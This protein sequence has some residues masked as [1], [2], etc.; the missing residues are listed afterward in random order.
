MW[1][2]I[3]DITILGLSVTACVWYNILAVE[4]NG[5]AAVVSD[6][7]RKGVLPMQEIIAFTLIVMII[8]AYIEKK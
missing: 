5:I 6:T 4:K 2:C 7:Y 1:L 8:I 3:G